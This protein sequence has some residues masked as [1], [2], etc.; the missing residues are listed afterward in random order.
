MMLD[1]DKTP[2]DPHFNPKYDPWDQRVCL[3]PDGDLYAALNTGNAEVV[4]DT[5]AGFTAKGIRLDSGNRI[6]TDI[7][8][9][10]YGVECADIRRYNTGS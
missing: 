4:T 3:V 10:R 9:T 5:I 8:V 1:Q 7:L 2:L 6:P